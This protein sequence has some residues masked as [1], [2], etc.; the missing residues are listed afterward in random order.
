MLHIQPSS[1]QGAAFLTGETHNFPETGTDFRT[2]EKFGWRSV[3]AALGKA[4]PY[5]ASYPP[6]KH[7]HITLFIS[8]AD[9]EYFIDG[10]KVRKILHSGMY[11]IIPKNTSYREKLHAPSDVLRIHVKE[12]V[13]RYVSENLLS[14]NPSDCKITPAIG[15]DDP[16]VARVGELFNGAMRDLA[17]LSSLQADHLSVI[18]ATR[19]IQ[20]HTTSPVFSVRNSD[21]KLTKTQ[22]DAINTYIFDNIG[23][24]V[25]IKDLSRISGCSLGYFIKQFKNSTGFTPHQYVMRLRIDH[26]K[27]L[28]VQGKSRLAAIAIDCG[29]SGQE[30]MTH[31]FKS[32]LGVT[33]GQF[34]KQSGIIR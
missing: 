24:P 13:L 9:I 7:T 34:I 23:N 16:L 5:Q 17:A 4:S 29:F 22:I 11:T 31:V 21:G 28:L 3:H 18:L 14:I 2:S 1:D 20:N 33:P 32:I 19:L 8:P 25:R 27:R 10:R 26:A 30:H 12:S 6:I 15:T